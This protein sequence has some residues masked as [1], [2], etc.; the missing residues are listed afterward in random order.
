MEPLISPDFPT[1]RGREQSLEIEFNHVTNDPINYDYNHFE[2]K[3]LESEAQVSF[4]VSK[5]MNVPGR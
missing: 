4:L 2:I 3:A 5:Y 1:S